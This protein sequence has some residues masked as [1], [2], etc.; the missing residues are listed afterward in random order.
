VGV[1][2][3]EDTTLSVDLGRSNGREN[4]SERCIII[5]LM[6][7]SQHVLLLS[8]ITN[9]IDSVTDA[10]TSLTGD[11]RAILADTSLSDSAEGEGV[12]LGDG[13]SCGSDDT[14]GSGDVAVDL[15]LS[16]MSGADL[17][18]AAA[19][20]RAFPA[21]VGPGVGAGLVAGVE[22]D[23]G[24]ALTGR[25]HDGV[26]GIDADEVSVGVSGGGERDGFLGSVR[27]AVVGAETVDLG[28]D[29]AGAGVPGRGMS[30]G[31]EVGGLPASCSVV[32][33]NS[34]NPVADLLSSDSGARRRVGAFAAWLR[35]A[36]GVE[37]LENRGDFVLE[38]FDSVDDRLDVGA[39]L[40]RLQL[41]EH[42]L[43]DDGNILAHALHDAFQSSDLGADLAVLGLGGRG[44]DSLLVLVGGLLVGL[45]VRGSGGQLVRRLLG[46]LESANTS[47]EHLHLLESL[48]A[49]TLGFKSLGLGIDTVGAD[50]HE[51]GGADHCNK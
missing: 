15:D 13:V 12:G 3:T 37:G 4:S 39:D 43:G 28:S 36:E 48:T 21:R 24:L 42:G 44:S 8:E 34:H 6:L 47:P 40:G 51:E 20:Q 32:V 1:G 49:E 31:S 25:G 23:L 33:V 41:V 50:S 17:D 11:L 26:V 5:A 27:E 10:D 14:L 29:R 2:K 19:E 18:V 22:A 16:L 7:H 9:L 38:F 46:R 35:E 45:V 30:V